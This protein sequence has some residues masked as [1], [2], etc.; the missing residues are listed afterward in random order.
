MFQ[1]TCHAVCG[2]VSLESTVCVLGLWETQGDLGA[3]EPG[4]DAGAPLPRGARG[5]GVVGYKSSQSE[6]EVTHHLPSS[7][8]VPDRVPG[9]HLTQIESFNPWQ[10]LWDYPL[11]TDE[12]I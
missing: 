5:R 8:W 4:D 11:L 7:P 12:V 10:P 2:A 6:Q 9:R 1:R 3:G